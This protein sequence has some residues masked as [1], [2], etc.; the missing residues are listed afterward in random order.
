MH[1]RPTT[2]FLATI[3]ECWEEPIVKRR[4]NQNL[5]KVF[6]LGLAWRRSHWIMA[7]WMIQDSHRPCPMCVGWVGVVPLFL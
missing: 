4:G 6:Q 5:P 1:S 7:I 3:F 2:V